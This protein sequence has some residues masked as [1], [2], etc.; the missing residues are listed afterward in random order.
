MLVTNVKVVTNDVEFGMIEN[1]AIEIKDD[2]IIDVGEREEI[3]KKYGK[4][5]K[6]ILD[7]RRGVVLPDL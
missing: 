6:E 2:E 3:E 1:G 7:G 4:T 5:E